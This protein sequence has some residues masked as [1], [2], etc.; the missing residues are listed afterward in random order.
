MSKLS[1]TE[2]LK[3]VPVSKTT[4]YADITKGTLSCEVD[5]KG[6]KRIDVSELERVYGPLE[7]HENNEQNQTSDLNIYEHNG[8]QNTDQN[9]LEIISLLKEQVEL[10][11]TEVSV[12]R[13]RE[14][15]LVEML[16]LEQKKTLQLMLPTPK[17]TTPSKW[18]RFFR[19]T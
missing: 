17:N 16:T 4:L 18:K 11:Q 10:L 14:Q 13:E 12:A 3:L 15:K 5:A 6:R 8:T 2:A 1:V 9:N 19:L 7:T